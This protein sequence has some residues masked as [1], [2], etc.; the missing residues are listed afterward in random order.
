MAVFKRAVEAGSFAAAARHFSISPEMAGNHVRALEAHLGV[1]L[2]NRSTRRLNPTEAGGIYY[3]HC[4]RILADILDAEAEVG[5][6]QAFPRGLLRVAA[7]VTFGVLHIAPAVSDY[8]TRY[9]EVRID[10]AVSDRFVN[11]IEEGF[12]LAIRV[13][14]L[15]DSNLIAR[16]LS[17][18]RLV[19]CAS[20]AYLQRAGRPETPSD[21][22]R[23][24]CL[25]YTEAASPET[26]RFQAADGHV[27]TVHVSGP[28]TSTNAAFVHRMAL[29][30]HGIVRGPSF[31]FN[32]DLAEGRLVPLLAG[33]RSGE[34]AIQALYPHKSL[35]SAKVRTFVD[36]LVE[37]FAL[38][39]RWEK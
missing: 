27:E 39:P 3:E 5:L 37:R 26:W 16:R 10:I 19:V 8:M 1:R 28:L 20:P 21:L 31:S 32:A 17:S 15:Q 24:A 33:W 13:G 14:E 2:L 29:A 38:A 23:H 35:L 18:A 36:F 30:G 6:L 25:I 7:P 4:T 11:L 22:S 9:P 12:D 34:L